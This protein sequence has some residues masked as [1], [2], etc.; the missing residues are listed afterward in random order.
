MVSELERR[1]AGNPEL[2]FVA[3][4]C[5]FAIEV[6][7]GRLP[8]PYDDERAALFARF[9]LIDDEKFRARAAWCD[10]AL[11]ADRDIGGKRDDLRLK[12]RSAGPA[13][14]RRRTRSG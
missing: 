6:R 12:D 1:P 3:F 9:A 14:W 2:V 4:M 13:A 11:A 8:G 5:A 7:L 10:A